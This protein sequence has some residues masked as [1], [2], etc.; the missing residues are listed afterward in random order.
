MV[1]LIIVFVCVMDVLCW[2][3]AIYGNLSILFMLIYVVFVVIRYNIHHCSSN[4]NLQHNVN[5]ALN[6]GVIVAALHGHLAANLDVEQIDRWV[7]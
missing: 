4:A 5:I 1:L 2:G 7:T 3:P 6:H